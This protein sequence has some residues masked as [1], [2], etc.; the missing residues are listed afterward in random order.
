[1]RAVPV[2]PR[3][4]AAVGG[5]FDRTS[6]TYDAL[7]HL[8]SFNVDRRWRSLLVKRGGAVSGSKILDVCTGTGD[9]AIQFARRVPGAVV[10]AVDF[11]PLMIEHGKAKAARRGLDSRLGFHVADALDLPFPSGSFDLVCN[12]FGVRT[13]TDH[14]RGIAEMT[15]VTRPGGRVMILEFERPPD[16]LFGRLYGW[17]LRSFM[18]SS[19]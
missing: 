16:T 14:R 10:E 2:D 11:S 4:P 3:S 1:V 12:S 8:L 17:Y 5:L 18:H 7:N 15:R 6:R 9:V 19:G 13:L